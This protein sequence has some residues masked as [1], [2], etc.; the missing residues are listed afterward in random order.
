MNNGSGSNSTGKVT[1]LFRSDKIIPVRTDTPPVIDGKLDEEIWSLTPKFT[2]FKTFKPDFGMAPSEKT[3]AYLTYDSYNLYF[4]M[5]CYDSE[6]EKIKASVTRRDNVFDED[7][8]ILVLDTFGDRQSAYAFFLNAFGIQGDGVISANGNGDMSMDMVWY[9]KGTID[10]KGYTVEAQVPFKSIRFPN[11]EEIEVGF[12]F[13][14]SIKR[15]S[16]EMSYPE[17]SPDGG[18]ILNQIKKMVISDISYQRA[19]EILPG[20]TH[21]QSRSVD[22]GKLL[23]DGSTND[24]SLTTKLGLTSELTLDGTYNPD[25]SQVEADAGQVDVNLRYALFYPE[26]RPFF[27][28]GK[29]YFDFAGNTEDAPLRTIVHTRRI[30]DPRLGLK[31][32]GKVGKKD[33]ISSIIATDESPGM[34]ED[35]DGELLYP[36]ERARFSILRHKHI[37]KEDGY[38]GGIYTGREFKGS[39]NRVLGS[40]GRFRINPNNIVEFHLLKSYDRDMDSQKMTPGHSLGLHYNYSSRRYNIDLGYQD[41]S[42]N[43]QT[44]TGYISRTGLNRLGAMAMV[45]LYP[46]S[47]IF[48]KI[49]PFYWSYHIRDKFSGLYE[50]FNLFCLRFHMPKNTQLRFE[51]LLGNEVFEARRF[52]TGGL[53]F[54][55]NSQITKKL[56]VFFMLRNGYRIY[57]DPDDPYQGRGK[58][59]SSDIA[60]QP[61]EKIRSSLGITFSDFYKTSN[62]ERIYDYT[63][64]RNRT[65]FQINKYLFFRGITEYNTYKKRLNCD[66]LASFTYIP[67]TVFHIGYGSIYEKT[68][69]E[70]VIM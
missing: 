3:E 28:E 6:P 63:I 67:G 10:E 13:A 9:S 41:V 25:Y 20:I 61:S 64:I 18:S 21:S 14:R 68:R 26:K 40:D 23:S 2:A 60:Y 7:N 16:E 29:E 46:K 35:D 54:R 50:T 42:K 11:K 58:T 62:S 44:E 4:A 49:D 66:F 45:S 39:Y 69:W 59:I 22:E 51:Y 33:M 56:F 32:T 37:L 8:T 27:L 30:N 47:K 53:G 70:D 55:S 34:E 38:I 24:L 5:R 12:A 17:L 1:G 36:G 52:N 31:L 19:I 15:R 48:Q 57:Y 65:T 43:F